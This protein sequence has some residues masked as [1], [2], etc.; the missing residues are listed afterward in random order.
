[1]NTRVKGSGFRLGF[2]WPES[3]PHVGGANLVCRLAVPQ[4]Q[5]MDEA[6]LLSVPESAV[7]RTNGHFQLLQSPCGDRLAGCAIVPCAGSPESA[8][9]SLYANLFTAIGTRT[10]YRVWNFVPHINA[11]L[12]GREQY[13][14]FNIG[15][16]QAFR[17]RYGEEHMLAQMPA[18]SAVGIDSPVLAVAFLAGREQ[19]ASFENPQQVPAYHYPEQYGPV[20][21]S[22]ARATVV[23]AANGQR[24]GYLSGTSSIRGH[25]TIGAGN[26]AEQFDTTLDNIRLIAA[27][28][29]F[30]DALTQNPP[31]DARFRV[32]LRR[33]EDFP[34]VRRRLVEVLGP[35]IE[36]RAMFLQAAICREALLLEIEGL[37]AS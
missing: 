9:H 30:A 18:A 31:F 16:C 24:T 27:R 22:F 23:T 14:S 37:F 21:P 10:L 35:G 32:Y 20:S 28:M 12:A 6:P 4:L 25:A 7:A 11:E 34:E 3:C 17:E 13:Q 1:M 33:R 36:A 26:L 8:A 19:V 2:G 15:R 29:G 5:G